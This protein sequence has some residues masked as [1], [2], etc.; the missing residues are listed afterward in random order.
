MGA[1]TQP[2]WTCYDCGEQGHTRNQCPKRIKQEEV[3]EVRGRAYAIKDAEP[4]G[5]NV[6]TGTFLLNNQYASILFDSGFDRSFVNTRFSSLLDIKPIKLED[7][8]EVELADG[9]I[10]STNTVKGC[11]LSLV[12]HV[13]EIDHMPIKLGTFDVII[14]TDKAKTTRK[15]L[16]PGKHEHKNGRARKK[17][18]GSYQSQKVNSQSTKVK[19]PLSQI[20]GKIPIKGH[21]GQF[22]GSSTRWQN[23]TSPNAFH[24]LIPSREDMLDDEKAQERWDFTLDTF[25][26]E[27]QAVSIMDCQAGNPCEI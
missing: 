18:G 12:N 19:L 17:P 16:K 7:S 8:Y 24:W 14:G 4:Q 15:W 23:L 22:M 9:R 6:V 26:K 5:P 11:T 21:K 27:A 10:A 3:R 1:N 2:I 20:M 25:S 13:F